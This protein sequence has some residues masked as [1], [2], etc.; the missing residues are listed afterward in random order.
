[1]TYYS[2]KLLHFLMIVSVGLSACTV[3]QPSNRYDPDNE[4]RIRELMIKRDFVSPGERT[5]IDSEVNYRQKGIVIG[6]DPLIDL[7]P[8]TSNKPVKVDPVVSRE[9]MLNSIIDRQLHGDSTA[10]M[11]LNMPLEPIR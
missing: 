7:T 11:P 4:R 5:I 1:M 3:Y 6:P 8:S 10:K 2:S 9:Q